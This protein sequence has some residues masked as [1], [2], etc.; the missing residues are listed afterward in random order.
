M[1]SVTRVPERDGFGV[2]RGLL[3]HGTVGR[4]GGFK[5]FGERRQ[6]QGG[7]LRYLNCLFRFV[8]RPMYV[9]A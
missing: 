7:F 1:P 8:I 5:H 3:R 9:L 6:F 2:L 4:A